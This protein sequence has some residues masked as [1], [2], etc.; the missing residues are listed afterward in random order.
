M[1]A[2]LI[3]ASLDAL[4]QLGDDRRWCIITG[5]NLPPEEFARIVQDSPPTVS[6]FRFRKDF[7][8]LLMRA[9]L[10]ISQAGYNT[11]CDLLRAPCNSILVPF[12]SGGETEQTVRAE[13]LQALGFATVVKESD[14]NGPCLTQAI[15]DIT[16]NRRTQSLGLLLDGA[17]NT[18]HWLKNAL[19]CSR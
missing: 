2:E 10:S 5:P 11:V 14:L 15:R 19:G 16:N 1:G 4:A 3:R 17:D 13:K 18:A 6:L 7:P 9:K 8:N 12:A